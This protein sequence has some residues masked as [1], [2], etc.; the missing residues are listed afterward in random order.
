M[1]LYNLRQGVD[2]SIYNKIDKLKNDLRIH[3]KGDRCDIHYKL[4]YN[5]TWL[6]VNPIVEI[7]LSCNRILQE[8]K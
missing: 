4:G 6:M 1:K 8:R 2:K 7:S 3:D 5:Q